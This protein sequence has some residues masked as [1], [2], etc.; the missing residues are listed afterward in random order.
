MVEAVADE[1]G[2]AAVDDPAAVVV[3]EVASRLLRV[4]AV[5]VE[6]GLE[7]VPQVVEHVRAA[8]LVEFQVVA[9]QVAADQAEPEVSVVDGPEGA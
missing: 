5:A 9:G 3:E 4:R 2:E 8:A 1:A 7:A 6:P